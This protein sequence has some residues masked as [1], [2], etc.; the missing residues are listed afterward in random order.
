MRKYQISLCKYD[1]HAFLSLSNC[2]SG[3]VRRNPILSRLYNWLLCSAL[4]Y[5]CLTFL[6]CMF[7]KGFTRLL[8]IYGQGFTIAIVCRAL[9]KKMYHCTHCACFKSQYLLFDNICPKKGFSHLTNYQWFVI[10]SMAISLLHLDIQMM[11]YFVVGLNI[12]VFTS[13]CVFCVCVFE[14]IHI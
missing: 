5:I 8:F 14:C 11:Q 13:V 4:Q 10:P 12:F 3:G 1:E 6:H 2:V 9:G 7:S